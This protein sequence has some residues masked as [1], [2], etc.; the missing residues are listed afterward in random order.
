MAVASPFTGTA[1]PCPP[2]YTVLGTLGQGRQGTVYRVERDGAE[3]ALKVLGREE[4]TGTTLETVRREAAKLATV[5]CPGVPRVYDVGSDEGR[6]YLVMEVVEGRPLSDALRTGPM[7]QDMLLRTAIGAAIA[8]A[9]VHRSHLLH[10]DVK[11]SNIILGADG[12]V[13]L[14]DFS[15]GAQLSAADDDG[16]VAGSALYSSPEQSGMLDR[17]LDARADLY[18]LGAVLYE[19]ATGT[20]PFTASDLGQLLRQHALAP[21][22]DLRQAAPH[23]PAAF[24]RIVERL[25][26]KEPDDR[27][28]SAA[29][30]LA[31]LREAA[32]IE[33]APP[34]RDEVPL[35]GR[36]AELET[37]RDSWTRAQHGRGGLV[38]VTGVS[39]AGKSHLV[40]ELAHSLPAGRLVLHGA[41][42][43]GTKQP[44]APLRAA[45]DEHLRELARLPRDEA[46]AAVRVLRAAAA[47][48][49]DIIGHL[50][51]GLR[52][53]LGTPASTG[54][55]VDETRYTAAVAGFLLELARRSHGLL[56]HLDDLQWYDHSTVR[57]LEHLA[58]EA[59]RAPLLVV[60]TV[61]SEETDAE[62]VAA[63][64]DML[65]EQPVTVALPPLAVA[66][67]AALVTAVNG[68][69]AITDRLAAQL[70]ARSGGNPFILT[71]YVRAIIDA[72]VATVSWGRWQV[73]A[74]VL[75]A[76]T[77]PQ[78]VSDL[79]RQ[80]VDALDAANRHV[81]GIAA[82]AGIRFRAEVLAAAGDL[83]HRSVVAL[84]ADATR[85]GLVEQ[86]DQ[87]A[88]GFLHERIREALLEQFDDVTRQSLHDRI[89]DVLDRGVPAD[90]AAV[91]AL[92]HHRMSGTPGHDAAATFTA[93]RA[94]GELALAE[95]AP[96]TAVALL[97]HAAAVADEAGLPADDSFG[98]LLAM[99]Y[100]LSARLDEA[101]AALNGALRQA[102]DPLRR[103]HLLHLLSLVHQS[104]WDS[105]R[106]ISAG[107][108]ALAEL[109][110]PLPR[111]GAGRAVSSAGYFLLS[112]LIRIT[113]IGSTRDPRKRERYLMQCA[114]YESL[115]SAYI[116]EL[117]PAKSVIFALRAP[118]LAGR[119]GL[120]V[121]GVRAMTAVAL[122]LEFNGL[123]GPARRVSSRVRRDAA[124]LGDQSLIAYVAWSRAI[125]LHGSG[126][127][128]GTQVIRMLEEQD[129]RLDF[130]L[131]LDAYA[132]LSWDWLL[133]GDMVAAEA[134][135]DRARRLAVASG[136][137]SRSAVVAADACLLALRGRAG[138][139]ALK[140]N[141]I[142]QGEIPLHQWVDV[143]I[144][145]VQTAI[146][147]GDFGEDFERAMAEFDAYG[148]TPRDLLP[149]QHTFYCLRAYAELERCRT[150]ADE[151]RPAQLIAT[152]AAL[153]TLGKVARRPILRAYHRVGQAALAVLTGAPEEALK[154]L[155]KAAADVR[156]VDAPLLEYEAARVQ[157][158]ALAALRLPQHAVRQAG[159]AATVAHFQGWP[160]RIQRLMAEF[161]FAAS[162]EETTVRSGAARYRDAQRQSALQQVSLAAARVL[163]P[164]QL[165]RIALDEV[166]RI[167]GAERAFL[168]LEGET[169]AG[170]GTHVGRD[171]YSQDLAEAHG[172]STHIV[173]QVRTRR[174]AVVVTGT[175]R[176][177]VTRSDS[178]IEYGLRSIV[179][180][181]V[182]LD[183]RL[184]GVVY[185]DSRL[186]KGVFT[187]GDLE[188]LSAV[189]HQ[190][191]ISL[192]TSRA[193]QLEVA[194][195]TA[196]HQRDL[197]ELLRKA[198]TSFAA[199]L[200][201]EDVLDRL[202]A[203]VRQSGATDRPCLITAT[204]DASAV[205]VRYQ[206]GEEVRRLRVEGVPDEMAAL[207]R[208][209]DPAPPEHGPAAS[210]L[211]RIRAAVAERGMSPSGSRRLLPL[212]VR[213]GQ[214]GLLV[215]GNT[216]PSGGTA[217]PQV[218]ATLAGQAMTAY[219]NAR[220][221]AQV[222]HMAAVDS[223][224]GLAN[225][226]SFF[227]RARQEFATAGDRHEGAV[228]MIDVDHFKR[229]NDGYGHHVGDEVLREVA[230]RLRAGCRPT[231]L[232][233]RYGGEEFVVLLPDR[234]EQAA[235]VA[236]RI[237]R[238][239]AGAPIATSAGPVPVTVSV[240]ATATAGATAVD[241]A[242]TRA[243]ACLYEA[244]H[245]GRN[246][247]VVAEPGRP[248]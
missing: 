139:A 134:G 220:L 88:Y 189:G 239:V 84:L 185:L 64:R 93:C 113:G 241:T 31:D 30:L 234:G 150:V 229:I 138:E 120:S 118:Y 117:Q 82:T 215:L 62:P 22:P 21:V 90:A 50:S 167:L 149:A 136:Q 131:A 218:I 95:W 214:L 143:L 162:A 245:A 187:E 101:V 132:V 47:D 38:M 13:R 61:R 197:A 175:D 81:L 15:L 72:G 182:V 221:F 224:T 153:E 65:G 240:G 89:A 148:L 73:D 209:V 49:A 6:P 161:G 116:R 1:P 186:A 96:E 146:E 203:A 42:A 194:V 211:Q 216:A 235:A 225:R 99:G 37:L 181:P 92:A 4:E 200:D 238:E 76:L 125:A 170:L 68:G 3:Y 147:R 36:D 210:A 60:L 98:E 141:T 48:T 39:G 159:F 14:I 100:H 20:P 53:L 12:I 222:H 129:H 104:A 77:L 11:P 246:R 26:A 166:I 18:S 105:E 191:A 7:P 32:G 121:E 19:A 226:R 188:L 17:A 184:L 228:L 144:G 164:A 83:P 154:R 5:R 52:S 227:D 107:E 171:A 160:H 173:D 103:A 126:R 130:G 172:Y 79:V 155:A 236:E 202:M 24:T 219:E 34:V 248:Q 74:A 51:D 8:L 193:A 199:T 201:P 180:A 195:A 67:T 66:A 122:L 165:V 198:M 169:A 75:D 110:R 140:L 106:Q 206:A 247:V 152:R 142:A 94:A 217:D 204:E 196:Q 244:K 205:T 16:R 63:V 178:M 135:L 56:L 58:A 55:A 177:E 43:H 111:R 231:D 108:Q 156:A 163:D 27:H 29:E 59:D 151:D 233:A 157:A 2:A 91:Y 102:T 80:R 35:I 192:E 124:A 213:D 41:G 119:T 183:D 223:L 23:L 242:L 190:I 46:E 179:A 97:E 10:G 168:L 133:R 243:D 176:G 28:Q 33:A 45:V 69:L 128:D 71:E 25:L 127:D 112:R 207:L 57:V 237:R 212:T 87:G 54:A 137:S 40:R 158:Y 86:Q 9:A 230:A 123:S 44:L 208:H 70:A 145:R 85:L 232:V 174:R 109:G 115:G 78:D 114:I